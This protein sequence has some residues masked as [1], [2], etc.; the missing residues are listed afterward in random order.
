MQYLQYLKANKKQKWKIKI[1]T[2]NSNKFKNTT[3]HILYKKYMKGTI[4]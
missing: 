3:Y 1:K 2:K 4:I